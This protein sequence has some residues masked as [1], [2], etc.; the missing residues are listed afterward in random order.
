MVTTV[1]GRRWRVAGRA[2]VD[3]DI[4]PGN[5]RLGAMIQAAVDY[6][7][8]VGDLGP[9]ELPVVVACR[10]RI[11]DTISQLPLVCYRNGAPLA[12]QPPVCVRPDPSEPRAA[13][14]QRL[15]HNL[16]GPGYAWIVTT[17]WYADEV[18]PAAI[19][20]VDHD[21]AHGVYDPSGRLDHVVYHGDRL[22][23]STRE[24]AEIRYRY[25]HVGPPG[26]KSGPL[27]ACQRAVE[28]LCALWQMSGSYWE[29][30]FPSLALVFD[31]ALTGQQKREIKDSAIAAMARRHEPAVIDRAGRLEAV[32]SSAVEAQLVESIAVANAEIVRAYGI[33]PS[34]VNVDAKYS[35]TYSTTEGELSNWLKLGL[36]AYLTRIEAVWSDLRPY[37]Q[38]VEFETG[39]LL[40]TDISARYAAY[41]VGWG[42]W[43]A[44]DEIRNAE[45][46]PVPAPYPI[47]PTDSAPAPP[48][49]PPVSVP[50]FDQ[51]AETG[52]S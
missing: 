50:L 33:P 27:G 18:T 10:D 21:E 35:L 15:A 2:A 25:D 6:R 3:A 32:G 13:T 52:M 48:P 43:L 37:G 39:R 4:P 34:V 19:R 45:G 5:V 16:S 41:E 20:V 11:A 30:G 12:D 42:K 36:S 28:Y 26:P 7:A 47:T 9:F 46:L 8:G 23:P 44:T 29:A 38:T 40:R 24:V 14:M 17:A 1:R 51:N 22:D 49:S 31:Q